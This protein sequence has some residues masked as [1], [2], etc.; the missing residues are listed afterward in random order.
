MHIHLE[1]H[2]ELAQGRDIEIWLNGIKYKNCVSAD[3]ERGY[4]DV[5]GKWVGGEY[6]PVYRLFGK[7][8][9]RFVEKAK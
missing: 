1:N 4:I 8:E 3:D 2:F 6:L 7:V 9:I 5:Y